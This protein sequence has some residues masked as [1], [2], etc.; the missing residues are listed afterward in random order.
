[1]KK[2]LFAVIFLVSLLGSCGETGPTEKYVKGYKTVVHK[3]NNAQKPAVG[4]YVFFNLDIYDDSG[5]VIDTS[6]RNEDMPVL[7]IIAEEDI[8]DKSNPVIAIMGGMAI[9]DS[10]SLYIPI[11]SIPAPPPS[12]IGSKHIEYV[13]ETVKI[14]TEEE[15]TEA[16]N[17]RQE[18]E[19]AKLQVAMAEAPKILAGIEEK[20]QDYLDGKNVGEVK[21]GPDGLKIIIV[22]AGEGPT[23]NDGQYVSVNYSGYLEDLSNFDNSYKRGSPYKLSLGQG[24]VIVGWDKGLVYLNKGAKAILD[25]PSE[26]GYGAAGSPPR[27]PGGSRLLFFVEMTDIN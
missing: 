8:P 7:Q 1:M 27:I 17:K 23:A 3:S 19:A 25:I 13:I 10:V 15:F 4:E 11:D 2:N 5:K 6:P 16:A 20:L 21:E 18:E 12:M 24:S 14:M 9:G 22:E 26:L